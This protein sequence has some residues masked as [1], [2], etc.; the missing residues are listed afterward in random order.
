MI[1][2]HN[3]YIVFFMA[4]I[5]PLISCSSSDSNG[6]SV[7]FQD[8]SSL[9]GTLYWS[10]AG[11]V[12]YYD[13]KNGKFKEKI[14]EIGASTS[15]DDFDVSWDRKQLLLMV[16]HNY[17]DQ[18]I[19]IRDFEENLDYEKVKSGN[20]QEIEVYWAEPTSPK[21]RISPSNKFV[22]T[23]ADFVDDFGIGMVDIAKKELISEWTVPGVN[24]KN[25]DLPVW[26]QNNAVYFR[27]GST[28]YSA[29]E[30]DYFS[31]ISEI[32]TLEEGI[33]DLTV[34]P[35]GDKM[36][37]V[38]DKHIWLS[39]ING[40]NAVQITDSKTIDEIKSDGDRR[41]VFSP[42][43]K[44]LAFVGDAKRG[45]PLVDRW[46]DGSEV[47]AI[48][49]GSGFLTIVPADGKLYDLEDE[50]SGAIWLTGDQDRAISV[51]RILWR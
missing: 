24:F 45:Y 19:V 31:N 40:G 50:N 13:L 9:K 47:S 2:S 7:E 12:G 1:S 5:S 29:S 20:N 49:S 10:F 18:E 36:A 30:S 17:N 3:L 37:Y 26:T 25:Y 35:Q 27:I 43:G 4:L 38:K 48:G 15:I 16:R 42:D 22:A 6:K 14:M 44:Y 34:S 21:G 32:A 33:K 8:S 46:F 28:L 51:T 39:D 23:A 11:E 41:P